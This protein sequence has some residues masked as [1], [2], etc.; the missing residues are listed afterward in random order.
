[1][2]HDFNGKVEIIGY[3]IRSD[4]RWIRQDP[5]DGEWYYTFNPWVKESE[6]DFY[7]LLKEKDFLEKNFKNVEIV[8][9]LIAVENG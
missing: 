7:R 8:P 6:N 5:G 1:M 3:A 2:I 9:I 4:K